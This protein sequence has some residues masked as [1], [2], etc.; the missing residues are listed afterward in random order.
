MIG[1]VIRDLPYL[2]LLHP[3]CEQFV[4]LGKPYTLYHWDAPRGSKEYNRASLKNINKS[5]PGVVSG[6]ARV[7][8]FSNDKQLF[9]Q[10]EAD[11]IDK[12]VSVEIWLWA[13]SYLH[14]FKKNQVKTY[15]ILYLTDS[16]WQPPE[17]ITSVY[18]VYYG[19]SYLMRAHHDFAGIKPLPT[20]DRAIG[21]PIFDPL[22]NVPSQGKD[23]LIL[24]PNLRKEHV[25]PAFGNAKRF[26]QMIDKISQGGNLIF[27][28]RKKQWLPNEIKP[29][30][31]EIIEDGDI[32]YP[33]VIADLFARCYSTV[34]FFSSGIYE[35]VS[36][37]QYVYNITIP[38]GRWGWDK[39]KLQRYFSTTAPA[40]YQFPGV[41]ESVDQDTVL[42]DWQFK[43]RHIDPVRREEW[44][45]KFI[46][47]A[48]G[49]EAIAKDIV[50]GSN[51]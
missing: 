22:P 38:L 9:K 24:L 2:K 44:I 5:S 3:I 42:G 20:R 13:K 48:G 4:V 50:N 18:R 36:G 46:G 43:P 37:G 14:W 16:I 30:A 51:Y 29:Y 40:V 47:S 34:M 27:K 1:V 23:I 6:A 19:S 31:K 39:K 33:P 35:C 26:I 11:K 8:A 25:Q 12:L 7:K 21:S 15:S 41:V 17:S 10:L 45:K 49:A 28:T 32:M